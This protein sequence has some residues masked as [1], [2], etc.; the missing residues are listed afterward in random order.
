MNEL[1]FKR[2]YVAT[3]LASYMASRYDS[4]CANGHIG[5][6]YDHQPI[7]DAIDLADRAWKAWEMKSF[8]IK[9]NSSKSI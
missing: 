9:V 4:D 5:E 3:F 7:E 2:N 8:A 1:E 6:P